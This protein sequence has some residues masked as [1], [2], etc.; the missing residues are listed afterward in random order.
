MRINTV[1]LFFLLFITIFNTGTFAQE[2][3]TIN[4]VAKIHL[5]DASGYLGGYYQNDYDLVRENGQW[6][7]YQTH[8]KYSRLNG[9]ARDPKK[10]HESKDSTEYRLIKAVPEDSINLFLNTLHTIKAKFSPAD[11]QVSIPELTK[12]VDTGF[13]KNMDEKHVQLFNSFFNTRAKLYHW[14]DTLQSDSW[15]DDGPTAMIEIVKKDGDTIKAVTN[16]QLDYMLPWTVNGVPDYDVNINRFFLTATNLTN[17]RMSGKYLSSH[18]YEYVDYFRARDAFERLRWQETAPENV[19]YIKQHFS[20]LKVNADNDHSDYIFHPNTLNAHIRVIGNLNIEDRGK[21][22]VLTKYAED[23]LKVFLKNR[24]FM[25]DSCETKPGC[26]VSFTNNF[27]QSFHRYFSQFQKGLDSYLKQ[28]RQQDLLP[29]TIKIGERT[30]D[31]W[32]ALPDGKFVLIAYVDD[33]A[34]GVLPEYIKKDG[35]QR[36]EFVFMIFSRDGKLIARGD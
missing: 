17:H 20:I 36:R 24:Q 9:R 10:I 13:L 21:L 4:D 19:K 25:I 34:V 33:H 31:D 8:E 29:F 1:S 14:L 12:Q 27:G 2:N 11:L 5:V 16:I 18:L 6:K 30:E 26:T 35:Y 32:I 22:E 28:F 3:I 15:T 23:T 7:T